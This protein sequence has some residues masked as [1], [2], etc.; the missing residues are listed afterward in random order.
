MALF[1]NIH[2]GS[3][4]GL[5]D[6]GLT[7]LLTS[8]RTVQGGSDI[9]P[10]QQNWETSYGVM[11]PSSPT[12]T[13]NTPTNIPTT[14]QPAATGGVNQGNLLQYFPGYAGWNPDAAWADYQ[15]TGG[16]GKGGTTS[17]GG[18][19]PSMD[20]LIN[21]MYAP[22]MDVYNQMTAAQTGYQSTALSGLQN[23]KS[24]LQQAYDL[25]KQRGQT[26]IG[27]QQQD[28]ATSQRQ[29]ESKALRDYKA[30]Q[31]Q[32]QARFG[33]ALSGTS[34]AVSEI[35]LGEFLRS[36][37]DLREAYANGQKVI[38]QKDREMTDEYNLKTTS[39][40]KDYQQGIKEINDDFQQKL[41]DIQLRKAGL[42]ADKTAQRVDA[43]RNAIASA[44]DLENRYKTSVWDLGQWNIMRKA[45][46]GQ[47][48]QYLDDIT[49]KVAAEMKLR[50]QEMS[51]T[52]GSSFLSYNPSQ[53]TQSIF[54]PQTNARDPYEALY[55]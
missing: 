4:G 20:E 54:R 40:E 10:N 42:E 46:L 44:R 30:A 29:A 16:A 23:S 21:S 32:N 45:E 39:L 55:A 51:Q 48:Q 37:G 50:Q 8:N 11:P 31:Q 24:A 34:N 53:S 7:E 43:M 27:N 41:S 1:E 26:L 15:S 25:A 38:F 17:G 3:W 9:I 33:G 18:G 19:G 6:L 22:A 49:A 35:I 36:G 14:T 13:G 2:A 52:V 47:S 5:P 28:L 12:P